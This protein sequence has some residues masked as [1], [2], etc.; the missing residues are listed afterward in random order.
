MNI[1]WRDLGPGLVM[2]GA[3]IGVSHLVQATRAGADFG[4]S[5]V[6]ILLLACMTKY[7][8]MDTGPRYA[9]STGENLIQGYLKIG[10]WAY[11]MFAVLT[12]GTMF[13]ILAA[14]TL[15]T[16]GLAEMIFGLHWPIPVWCAIILSICIAILMTGRYGILDQSMK[17]IISFLTLATLIAVMIAGVKVKDI[18]LNLFEINYATTAALGFVV[19]LMGWMPIPI[20]ASVWHSIWSLEKGSEKDNPK[21][22]KTVMFDF[23]IGYFA[24]TVIGVFFLLLGALVMYQKSQFSPNPVTFSEQLISL[25][26]QNLG[27]WSA[28]LI[29]TAAFITM[30]STTFAITDAY[31]RV[32]VKLM[33]AHRAFHSKDSKFYSGSYNISLVSIPII[34]WLIIFFQKGSFTLMVDFATTVSFLSA[35]LFAW[36]NLTLVKSKFMPTFSK[37]GTLYYAWA[38]FS[39]FFLILFCLVYVYSRFIVG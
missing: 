17:W 31:P 22:F 9:S 2:A 3:A 7:P 29:S 38:Y 25:Y 36:L 18:N 11:W 26:A 33:A 27:S 39:L 21:H 35:P 8:F 32:L 12:F 5:L 34:S 30:F 1:R 15:V 19:A 28:P 24:A 6:W 23:K 37:P 16:G 14:V 20:D 13:I 10:S 4:F